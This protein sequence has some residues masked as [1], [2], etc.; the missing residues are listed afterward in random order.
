M[1]KNKRTRSGG[2]PLSGLEK[3]LQDLG[4][5][6]REDTCDLIFI[7]RYRRMERLPPSKSSIAIETSRTSPPPL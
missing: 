3:R 4:Q 2:Q 6:V 1:N 5:E 7:G